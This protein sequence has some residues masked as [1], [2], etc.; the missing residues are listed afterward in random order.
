MLGFIPEEHKE[1]DNAFCHV[2]NLQDPHQEYIVLS[3]SDD[4]APQQE[5]RDQVPDFIP[6][7]FSFSCHC[8]DPSK[9]PLSGNV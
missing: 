1:L 8:S 7:I 2:A 3:D 6:G 5:G 9:F 4:E